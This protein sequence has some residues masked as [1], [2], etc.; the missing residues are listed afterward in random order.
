MKSQG[1]LWTNLG[2]LQYPPSS[3]FLVDHVRVRKCLF[4]RLFWSIGVEN[5]DRFST[6]GLPSVYLTTKLKYTRLCLTEKLRET[7]APTFTTKR[8]VVDPDTRDSI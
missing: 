3:V 4:P 8:N 1:Q 7:P 2:D 6:L 5:M